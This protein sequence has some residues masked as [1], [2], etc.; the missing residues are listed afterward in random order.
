VY[1]RL[2]SVPPEKIIANGIPVFG[3]F[4]EPFK[5]LDI[6]NVSRPFGDLPL[7]RWL[8]NLRIR[9]HLVC[10]FIT[11]DYVGVIDIFDSK[12][13]GFVELIV[14][15]QKTGKKL[16]YRCVLGPHKRI[17]PKSTEQ[18]VCVSHTR[19]RYVRISWCKKTNRL[20]V[21]FSL[22]GDDARPSI[23]A[24]FNI[25]CGQKDFARTASVVPAQVS[26]RCAASVLMTGSLHGTIVFTGIQT[27]VEDSTGSLML[28]LKRAYYPLRTK[29]NMLLGFGVF[30]DK[31][32]S[33]RI[34]TSNLDGK[35]TYRYNENVLFV[36]GELTLLPPVK[37][38][39][40]GGIS[41]SWII[42]DTESMVDLI[43]NPI[44]DSYR[45]LS[46][47]VLHTNYHTIYGSFEGTFLTSSGESISFKNFSGIGKKLQLRY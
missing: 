12:V 33:F 41:N 5:L 11:E 14:W 26:R 20:S 35:D 10:P 27:A 30:G 40:P 28:E 8:T 19:K 17:V 39:Y 18:D 36:D 1:T 25:D 24:A 4:T 22:K 31:K 43:F 7:P 34:S 2:F 9:A 3:T 47:L 44:S 21:L 23:E 37:I 6:R 46:V 42:Q 16:A 15:E 13:F 38:T 29:T 45:T 32:I